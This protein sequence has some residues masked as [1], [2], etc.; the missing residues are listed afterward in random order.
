MAKTPL[1]SLIKPIEATKVHPRTGMS[2]GK[3]DVTV[4]YGALIEHVGADRD[5]EK[6]TYLGEFYTCK[7]DA[8]ESATGGAKRAS[9]KA[10]EE[11]EPAPVSAP[12]PTS[13]A[14][15]APEPAPARE[16]RLEWATLD[17][18]EY[19]VR[20]AAVSGGWLVTLDGNGVTF[21]PDPRHQWDGGS[22][23]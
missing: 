14:E 8:F 1:I 6:F 17:S 23:E 16:T 19:K 20:R 18:S 5:H 7:H 22:P 11:E 13:M 12:A 3:P 10:A 2:L 21:V 15:P 9:K 4:P